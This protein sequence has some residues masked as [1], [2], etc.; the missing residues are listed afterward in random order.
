MIDPRGRDR[1]V[2][3]ISVAAE[4]AG[5][6]PQTL[7]IYDRRG[8]VQPARTGGGSRRYSDADIEKLRRVHELT[9]EGMNLDGVERVL[10]LESEVARLREQVAR[11]TREL[12]SKRA[13][14][15][16]YRRK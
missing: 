6:H 10:A 9:S 4:L 12:E 14:I 16:L 3:V 7:R 8:L 11:L 15:V 2:Y 13:D 1:A 5:I